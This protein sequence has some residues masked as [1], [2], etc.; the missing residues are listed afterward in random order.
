MNPIRLEIMIEIK[1]PKNIVVSCIN[2][3]VLVEIVWQH[4]QEILIFHIYENA[5]MFCMD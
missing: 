2:V 5:C 3:A 1:E 4:L